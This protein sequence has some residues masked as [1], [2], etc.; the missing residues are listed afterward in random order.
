[1]EP[2]ERST[3]QEFGGDSICMVGT[4]ARGDF[5][6]PSD[7]VVTIPSHS[8]SV[9]RAISFSA[10][11]ISILYRYTHQRCLYGL[12]R[13]AFRAW[14]RSPVRCRARVRAPCV[15]SPAS[16]MATPPMMPCGEANQISHQRSARSI[17][18]A[19]SLKIPF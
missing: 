11:T 12:L 19:L 4:V 1:M 18:T 10:T 16:F 15:A 5:S 3:P 17:K 7:R 6:R 2:Q 8:H 13:G 14:S 9:A